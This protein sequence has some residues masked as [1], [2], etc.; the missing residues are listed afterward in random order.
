MKRYAVTVLLFLLCALAACATPPPQEIRVIVVHTD[1]EPGQ[2]LEADEDSDGVDTNSD[3]DRAKVGD[4]DYYDTD[5][6]YE[7]EPNDARDNNADQHVET[8]EVPDNE[9]WLDR[10]ETG[11]LTG[12]C[13]GFDLV[14]YAGFSSRPRPV[15]LSS[16]AGDRIGRFSNQIKIR[17]G[18]KSVDAWELGQREM[19]TVTDFFAET[20][21]QEKADGKFVHRALFSKFKTPKSGMIGGLCQA[22]A[23]EYSLEKC[24]ALLDRIARDGIPGGPVTS[25]RVR[26][27]GVSFDLAKKEC[28][29]PRPQTVICFLESYTSWFTGNESTL[30]A[31][32]AQIINEP[33]A[34]GLDRVEGYMP[35]TLE[36]HA[37]TIGGMSSKCV[38]ATHYGA[39][40][41]PT[42]YD[43]FGY[44]PTQNGTT[45]FHCSR[46][47]DGNYSAP[48]LP[49]E[50]IFGEFVKD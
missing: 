25:K 27:A 11:I 38:K 43:Y 8:A 49:C 4:I 47:A 6:G 33:A 39:V 26:V 20:R 13:D 30:T 1:K 5:D 42:N 35:P 15:T 17:L 12:R 19:E 29:A 2:D 46:P 41:R 28:W 16:I 21:Q 44:V 40:R 36:E 23:A 31:R 18:E 24:T 34:A 3:F 45:M 48:G 50:Q 14:I 37:C 9:C 32:Q 10:D 7:D 22:P